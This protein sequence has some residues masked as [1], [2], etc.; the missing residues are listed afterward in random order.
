LSGLNVNVTMQ[1][2]QT[3][4][5]TSLHDICVRDLI[6]DAFYPKVCSK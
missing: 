4:V 6:T 2:H 5:A 1:R 3:S